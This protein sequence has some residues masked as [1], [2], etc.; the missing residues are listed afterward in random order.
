MSSYPP[1]AELSRALIV[2]LNRLTRDHQKTLRKTQFRSVFFSSI[3]SGSLG[4]ELKASRCYPSSSLLKTW[5]LRAYHQQGPTTWR[6]IRRKRFVSG[7]NNRS[8][9]VTSRL[10]HQLAD[11]SLM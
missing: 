6:R 9:W 1:A 11:F 10:R 7:P 8:P 5:T 4:S 3:D 2:N